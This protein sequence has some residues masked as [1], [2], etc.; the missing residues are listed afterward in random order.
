MVSPQTEIIVGVLERILFNN[1]ET[2]F[3]VGK[4]R[5]DA[6]HQLVT[7]VGSC[8]DM[9]CGQH[10]EIKGQWSQDP[11]YGRQFKIDNTK[12]IAPQT[13][14][15]I[16]KYLGSGLIKGIGPAMAKK[17]VNKFQM[18]TLNILEKDPGKLSLIE[19][20]GPQRI[21]NIKKA[22][23]KHRDL[24]EA[25]VFL[26]TYGLG[27]ALS[28][29]VYRHYGKKCIDII[30]K[31]PY[32]LCEDIFGIGFK[33]ADLIAVN[34]GI[35]KDSIFR[36]KAG[37]IYLL[38]N[39]ES[40]GHCYLPYQQLID[41]A[42]DFL[43]VEVSLAHKAAG[44]LKQEKKVVIIQDYEP[45][46]YLKDIYESE[47][48]V[49]KKLRQ[50]QDKG[51][52]ESK[53]KIINLT[54]TMEKLAGQNNIFLDTE[55]TQAIIA[56]NIEKVLVIT[57]SPGTGKSTIMNFVLATLRLNKKKVMLAAPT[58]RASKRLSQTT[59]KEAKTIHRMLKYNPKTNSFIMNEK[60]RLNA[61]VLVIDEASM[62]DIRLFYALLKAVKEESQLIL[63]GDADQ[64][65]SVGPG[66]IL[67]DII[68]SRRFPVI[69]LKKI[70]RQEG[71]SLIIQNAHK[72]RDGIF[73]YTGK[74]KND[75]FFFIE[76]NDPQQVVDLIMDL[77]L[78][79][80]PKR[81]GFDP[82]SD[83]QVLVPTNKGIVG[84]E[85][86]NRS[87]QDHINTSSLKINGNGIEY[88]LNDKVIQLKN[89]YEKDIYNGDIGFI[90]YIEPKLKEITV[91]FEG[92][93]ILYN[94]YELDEISLSYA[95]SIHKSQGSEFPCIIVPI[96]TSH[97][98]LLQRNLLYTAI[99]RAQQVAVLI[100]SKKAMGIAI[101]RNIVG[102]RFTGLKE[103]LV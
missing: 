36:A 38:E 82:L 71:Q 56:A 44:Q 86:L 92:R 7:I 89:N 94:F 61:D 43:Q 74:P 31:N 80:L 1:P 41:S 99:T 42:A 103:M 62:I 53:A 50:I 85:N 14:E 28:I 54:E 87:L 77:V 20:F 35:E 59:G 98:M 64:L 5:L 79:K 4:V 25:M 26:R 3:L 32:R 30:K 100:G 22:W 69:T 23:D 52:K 90:K 67:K 96:L 24:R 68:D 46:I 76:K 57:G 102:D 29:K 72:I 10:L 88:R 84:V 17:I 51:L 21:K 66:N 95:I 70:Y 27:H 55:Q 37:I 2:G 39:M 47:I 58:G 34:M 93:N 18:E 101:N 48:Y 63:V 49:S 78:Q 16:E 45:R 15:G 11:K 75:D 13:C 97:Y 19:G 12:M 65:P 91:N 73:P 40:A 81:F 83:I 8:P 60:D 33:T 9:E 6:N